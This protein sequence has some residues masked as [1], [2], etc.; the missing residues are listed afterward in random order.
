MISLNAHLRQCFLKALLVSNG[1]VTPRQAAIEQ[2]S[3]TLVTNLS[4]FD[5]FN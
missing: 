1:A 3:S 2:Q 5:R 4:Q